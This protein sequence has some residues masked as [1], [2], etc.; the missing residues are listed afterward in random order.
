MQSSKESV[1]SYIEACTNAHGLHE[2]EFFQAGY[3]AKELHI[4][5]SLA[6]QYL[7]ALYGEGL[8]VKVASRPALYYH[9]QALGNRL[10]IQFK[11]TE[12]LSAAELDSYIDCQRRARYDFEDVVG[13][14]GSCKHIIEQLKSAACYPPHGLPL[15]LVGSR[16]SGK[17]GLR[18]ALTRWCIYKRIIA[19]ERCVCEVDVCSFDSTDD[20]VE[21]LYGS[22]TTEGVLQTTS[23]VLVWLR[24]CQHVENAAWPR[25]LAFFNESGASRSRLFFEYEG[26]A[27]EVAGRSW[28]QQIPIVCRVPNMDERP[29]EERE[30]FIYRFLQR[31]ARR[32]GRRILVSSAVIKRLARREYHDNITGLDNT[33]RLTC[34]S[35]MAD[36]GQHQGSPLRVFSAHV[37]AGDYEPTDQ[38][39]LFENEPT[40]IDVD[41][42]D[43]HARSREALALIERFVNALAS[44]EAEPNGR[45]ESKAKGALSAYFEHV[46]HNRS[47]SLQTRISESTVVDIV[48]RIFDGNGL[49]EP[50]NFANHVAN[51]FSFVRSNSIA[52]ERWADSMHP[53]LQACLL[54]VQQRYPV[55]YEIVLH[56][57]RSLQDCFGWDMDDG[58][59][60]A[61]TFYL[62]WYSAGRQTSCRGV[63]VAH[64]YSTASSIADSVNTMLGSYVFD[65]VDMPLEVSGE[66]VVEKL[67]AHLQKAS[68]R[69]DLLIMV[70][71]GSLE[72]IGNRLNLSFNTDIGVI[73]NVSTATALEAGTCLL[74]GKPL[75][76]TLESVSACS[77]STFTISENRAVRDCIA[78][79]SE[80]GVTAAARLAELFIKSLPKPIDVDIVTCDYF[81]MLNTEEPPEALANKRVL[82]VFGASDPQMTG[83][84]FVSL[85]DIVGLSASDDVALNLDGYFSDHEL[86][87]LKA[88]LVRNFSLE[89]LMKHLTILEPM[90]LMDAVSLSLERL[91]A[92]MNTHFSY[93]MIMRLYIHAS[94]L[95]ERLVTKDA[96]E[97][98]DTDQF[99]HDHE[100]FVALVRNSFENITRDYGVEVPISEINFLYELICL[101]AQEDDTINHL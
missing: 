52:V 84:R 53:R 65:A 78:F 66:E 31:E 74:Q 94:Y 18:H 19:S 3:A 63:I 61:F 98:P 72:V 26:S 39:A 5:R 35:A 28:M 8:L 46:A 41:L 71:M 27:S 15:L 1:L 20:L 75:S 96:I 86:N 100:R 51:T 30:T 97:Y 16:G 12:F 13:A 64:G 45:E 21:Y 48:A 69:N 33:I 2:T 81:K 36:N 73:N 58:S 77:Q 14:E 32:I 40:Y 44:I 92:G 93:K 90:R 7:N 17:T 91:Q 56:L 23:P 87:E 47:D 83:V 85:E 89:N 62:Q 50:V 67:Q 55:E 43:P 57:K 80:N 60:V 79:V 99:E 76:E 22:E 24:N 9:R 49:N 38:S 54:L 29:A 37:P 10:Q 42:Y 4:S 82:F 11:E 70:D 6:S 34:A 68:V 25:L 95:V 88:N 59:L 101:E